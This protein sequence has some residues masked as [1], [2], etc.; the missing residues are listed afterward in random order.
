MCYS[1][2]ASLNP[3]DTRDILGQPS[4]QNHSDHDASAGRCFQGLADGRRQ[5]AASIAIF[6]IIRET[7]QRCGK[8]D[9]KDAVRVEQKAGAGDENGSD[10]YKSRLLL[11]SLSY[12][13]ISVA[14]HRG[15]RTACSEGNLVD[16]GQ[17][18]PST[19]IS[20]GNVRIVVVVVVKGP[21][22]AARVRLA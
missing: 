11:V 15:G 5:V 21:V 10:V 22:A 8:V 6:A 14:R 19:Q 4:K 20:V 2:S 12:V 3:H 1:V 18:Q 16:I 17:R 9:G 13:S 7:H